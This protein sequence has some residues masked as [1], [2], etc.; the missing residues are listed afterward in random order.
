MDAALAEV[1]VHGARVAVLVHEGDDSAEV[2]AKLEGVDGG[3]L[4][5]L[6][7]GAFAW[8]EGGCAEAGLA[9]VPDAAGFGG[10]V[11]AG[12]GGGGGEGGDQGVGFGVGFGLGLA[13]ELGEEE[14]AG[15]GGVGEEGEVVEGFLLGAEGVEEEAV[16]AFE[17]DEG[18]LEEGGDLVGGVEDRAETARPVQGAV[19]A[20]DGDEAKVVA[21]EDE[22][23]GGLRCRRG[24]GLR[25]SRFR[26]GRCSGEARRG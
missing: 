20:G 4:P 14:A 22:G 18:V 8:D 17:A 24:R 9:D 3:V 11:D 10:G 12:V 1:A 6:P 26:A 16:D 7:A 15:G 5:S 25:G 21:R 23:A 13:A 19:G 2:G